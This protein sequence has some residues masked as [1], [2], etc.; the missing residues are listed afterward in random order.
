MFAT[1][2]IIMKKIIMFFT[3][4][5]LSLFLFSQNNSIKND[6]S[7]AIKI[8]IECSTC[9]FEYIKQE[10]TYVNYVRD[11]KEAQLHILV[12]S[13]I[14]GSGGSEYK[15][16]FS[17][18]LD[19]SGMNDTLLFNTNANNTADEIRAKFLHFL[20]AGLI[21]YV[22]KTNYINN[23]SF[24]YNIPEEKTEVKDK[25][26][27][28]VFSLS[29]STWLNAQQ[30]YNSITIYSNFNI[31]RITEKWKYNF[32]L[33][34]N[35]NEQKYKITDGNI[36]SYNKSLYNSILIVKSLTNHW[37]A[38]ITLGGNHSTYSNIDISYYELPAIEYNIFPYSESSRKQ[39]TI[40]YNIGHKH[41]DYIDTTIYN[42]LNEN[43]FTETLG[44]GFKTIQKW[45]NINLSLSGQ[46][47]MH[48]FS[49]NSLNTYITAEIR[50]LKGL[51]FNI[52]GYYSFVRNQLS[53]PKEG[54][55]QE[56]I[57][58]H[59]KELQTNF[60]YY[61]NVGLT[62]TFGSIY[63]NVVNP[64]FELNNN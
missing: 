28:W 43:L 22:S 51:S 53:L 6:K 29:S 47:Y 30:T 39:F 9:D 52:Y 45:G 34:H 64:R 36:F 5:L 12:S 61:F 14:T 40:R 38:G 57:L 10:I 21:R 3:C 4:N 44:I 16:F 48:D 35:Y 55:T 18:Q 8:F 23:I 60:N 1:N 31:D 62:Y 33:G 49:K 37:S 32:Y 27:S 7:T 17:G 46:N 13:Q 15:L 41:Q 24:K 63:N 2:I 58:L 54:A 19:L 42:K 56:E 25:W 20:Q 26:D 11:P 50:I 59:Q